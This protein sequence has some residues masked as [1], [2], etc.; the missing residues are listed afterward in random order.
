MAFRRAVAF[1]GRAFHAIGNAGRRGDAASEIA[2]EG[3]LMKACLEEGESL[4]RAALQSV[5]QSVP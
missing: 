5:L 4:T 2:G 3:R 1:R